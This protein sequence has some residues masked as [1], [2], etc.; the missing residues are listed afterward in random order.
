MD[1]QTNVIDITVGKKNGKV[2]FAEKDVLQVSV[3]ALNLKSCDIIFELLLICTVTL[4]TFIIPPRVNFST[5]GPSVQC[6]R[7]Q[8]PLH[9]HLHPVHRDLQYPHL[10][11][12]PGPPGECC[13]LTQ[14][15]CLFFLSSM[16]QFICLQ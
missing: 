16:A 13:W 14:H 10:L 12:G 8:H 5:T 3:L 15:V 2:Y 7:P 1:L 9:H 11:P 4:V 6:M